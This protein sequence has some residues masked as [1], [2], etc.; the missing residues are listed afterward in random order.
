MSFFV[1]SSSAPRAKSL[2]YKLVSIGLAAL[3]VVMVTAQLFRY[4]E[5]AA[6]FKGLLPG[7][8][9]SVLV[10]L[11]VVFEVAALPFLLGMRLSVLARWVSMVAGWIVASGWTI[12][13]VWTTIVDI[14]NSGIL[15]ATVVIHPGWWLVAF[16]LCLC[17]AML[18][19]YVGMRSW[20]AAQKH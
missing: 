6:V 19:V 11:I 14:D 1:V 13:G 2:S 15:G 16:G 10:A 8:V 12:L 5:F 3:L 9:A 18:W 17:S 7:E 4:E 20:T